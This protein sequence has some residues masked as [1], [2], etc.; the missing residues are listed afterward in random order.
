MERS[1]EWALLRAAMRAFVKGEV[2]TEL[3]ALTARSLDWDWI[4]K[5][6]EAERIAAL[7]HSVTRQLV[8]PLP[9]RERLRSAWVNGWRWYVSTMRAIHLSRGSGRTLLK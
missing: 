3:S 4:L 7:L 6:A 1:A 2:S 5:Q 9:A 8:V